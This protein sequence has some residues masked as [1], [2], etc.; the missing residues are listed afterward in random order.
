MDEKKFKY[1][2]KVEKDTL[3]KVKEYKKLLIESQQKF[4]VFD[5]KKII[6]SLPILHQDILQ[7][8]DDLFKNKHEKITKVNRILE[9]IEKE[10]LVKKMISH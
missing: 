2:Q 1:F 6:H 4:T 5:K 8:I 3:V 9:E 10:K 7:K